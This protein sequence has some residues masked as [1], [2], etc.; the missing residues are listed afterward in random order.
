MH[1]CLQQAAL[2]EVQILILQKIIFFF[3]S[4]HQKSLINC[5]SILNRCYTRLNVFQELVRGKEIYVVKI[6]FTSILF[7]SKLK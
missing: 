5:L 2:L 3:E 1:L 6:F 4:T 7:G